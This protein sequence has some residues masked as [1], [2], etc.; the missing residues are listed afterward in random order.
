MEA[1]AEAALRRSPRP[2]VVLYSILAAALSAAVCQGVPCS[3]G[4]GCCT[5]EPEP[6]STLSCLL[7]ITVCSRAAWGAG[8]C[9]AL[10]SAALAVL[11][12]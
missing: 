9:P 6:P 2:V 3:E 5:L 7:G 10:G 4:P 12:R 1:P 11:S 8:A